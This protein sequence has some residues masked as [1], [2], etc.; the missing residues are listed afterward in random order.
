M[1]KELNLHGYVGPV[2]FTFYTSYSPCANCANNFVMLQKAISDLYGSDITIEIVA[3]APYK[4]YR[5]SCPTCQ[6]IFFYKNNFEDYLANALGLQKLAANKMS[7]RAFAYEDWTKLAELLGLAPPGLG[8]NYYPDPMY[9]NI[10][11]GPMA[12]HNFHH[13]RKQADEAARIDFNFILC[14][15]VWNDILHVTDPSRNVLKKIIA[16]AIDKSKASWT[17]SL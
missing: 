11:I 9:A 13:T 14:H 17:F 1:I 2:R 8:T 3:A 4:T 6:K 15:P 10:L 16:D 7:V 12:W 5:V